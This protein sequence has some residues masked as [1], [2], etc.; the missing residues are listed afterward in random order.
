MTARK[1]ESI[2]TRETMR[3]LPSYFQP[4]L[5]WLTAKPLN[6]EKYILNRTSTYHLLTACLSVLLGVFFSILL[7]ELN[8][9]YSIFLILPMILTVSGFRKLQ[10]VIYHHCS[11]N[12]V[13]AKKY[14]NF[15][16]GDLISIIL[17]IK[18][19][20]TYQRDHMI[21][22]HTKGLLT[23]RDETVQ[24]LSSVGLL[25]GLSKNTLYINMLL[26]F[27]SPFSQL[28]SFLNRI[29][30]SLLSPYMIHN[31]VAIIYWVSLILI[32]H[33]F[34]VDKEFFIVWIIPLT[35]LYHISRTLRLVVEH[36]WPE[37]VYLNN[38]NLDFISAS[39]IAVFPGEPLPKI[40]TSKVKNIF[41]RFMWLSRMLSIHLF[42]RIFVL[43]GDTP[44]HD[45]HHR[46]PTSKKWV[47]YAYARHEDHKK[48]SNSYKIPYREIWGILKAIDLNFEA[49][50]KSQANNT[51]I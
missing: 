13:F 33:Y 49:M 18:D 14:T 51:T 31:I 26:S 27:V 4:F 5:T 43:V 44:C 30:S 20:R 39:T 10:V 34:Q 32:V 25:P 9:Y 40:S 2:N 50:S 37:E 42:A 38:R 35:L 6:H 21:H 41:S 48:A 12:N 22:H 28:R 24:D 1:I 7:L 15:I 29:N 36:T 16:I 11:H 45:H 8:S 47:N 46:N 3:S 17:L 19:F 23:H